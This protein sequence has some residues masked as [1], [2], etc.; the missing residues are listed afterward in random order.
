MRIGPGIYF[1]MPEKKYHSLKDWIDQS[2]LKLILKSPRKY[3]DPGAF[4]RS[5][6]MI[7]GSAWSCW[8][9]TPDVYGDLYI[10][11][12]WEI[13]NSNYLSKWI[14]RQEA[15]NPG[16]IVLTASEVH[17][18]T[19]ME[20]SF[21]TE[22]R[23]VKHLEGSLKEVSIFWEEFFTCPLCSG[24]GCQACD[25]SGEI[26]LKFKARI[27]FIKETGSCI[28][29]GDLKT[30]RDSSIKA[31]TGDILKRDYRFQLAFYI[32]ALKHYL[33]DIERYFG[34]LIA[35][36]KESTLAVE[37]YELSFL[38]LAEGEYRRQAA[39][40]ILLRCMTTSN[41]KAPYQEQSAPI[42]ECP[43]YTRTYTKQRG[44]DVY[45]DTDE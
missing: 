14:S 34:L 27:D 43:E 24:E 40:E 28:I 45:T 3:M 39:I 20:E 2:R 12:P 17:L 33:Q 15:Q 10:E 21:M 37:P 4:K 32:H 29:V 30:C 42:I 26:L 11:T 19:K 41:W 9:L 35:C 23:A 6:A 44:N 25:N 36:E 16:K 8:M 18:L 22:D 5:R 13:Q 7:F 38:D 31:F 1:G